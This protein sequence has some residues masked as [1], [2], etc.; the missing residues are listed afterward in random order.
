MILSHVSFVKKKAEILTKYTTIR[1]IMSFVLFHLSVSYSLHVF[2]NSL[3]KFKT[4]I[5][6]DKRSELSGF[7]ACSV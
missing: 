6:R 1:A 7:V 3:Q 5:C 2:F 4:I